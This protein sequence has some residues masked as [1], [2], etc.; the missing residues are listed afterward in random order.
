VRVALLAVAAD[1]FA[2]VVRILSGKR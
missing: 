1:H 2:V